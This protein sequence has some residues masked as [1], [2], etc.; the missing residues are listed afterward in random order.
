MLS[1]LAGADALEIL[2]V[3]K[4][5][6]AAGLKNVESNIARVEGKANSANF[7]GF[8]K[9]SKTL[10]TD[11]EK[12]AGDAEK[13][14]GGG[15]GNLIGGFMGIPTPVA[16]AGGAILAFAGLA[17]GTIPI[18]QKTQAEL[19]I[20]AAAAKAHGVNMADLTKVTDDATDAAANYGVSADDV[21]QAVQGMTLAGLTAA[22]QQQAMPAILNLS[23]AKHLDLA[24]AT[25]DVVKA[26]MGNGKAL[27]DLGIII[28]PVSSS[29]ADL[30]K[31][32]GN[33]ASATTTLQD[34]QAK[35]GIVE[36]GLKGKHK[37]TAAE[38]LKLKEAHDKVTDAQKKLK[39]AQDKLVLAQQ[40]GVDKGAALKVVVDKITGATG[41]Q[42][43]SID[44][45]TVAQTKLNDAWDKFSNAVAPGLIVALTAIVDLIGGFVTL[46][47]KAVDL[48][49]HLGDANPQKTVSTNSGGNLTFVGGKYGAMPTGGYQASS[50]APPKGKSHYASGGWAG[51]NGPELAWLGEDG[52]EYVTPNKQAMGSGSSG[53]HTTNIYLDGKQIARVIEPHLDK[54]TGKRLA[55]MGTSGLGALGV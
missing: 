31:A 17:G 18:Y 26:M 24:T 2:V 45:L 16:L 33:V 41:D 28:P 42:K 51:L 10:K 4:D 48:I 27:K 52:P 55:L 36:D 23:V 5:M 40:G 20:T 12:A 35:L 11:A 22:Q 9:S 15:L 50:G 7:S 38:A 49:S 37:L 6:S 1:A 29:A 46:L 14:G 34:A 8:S 13:G 3:L 54:L 43:G 39:A 25:D 47:T 32:Q 19:K 53:N 44:P 30:G 21:R